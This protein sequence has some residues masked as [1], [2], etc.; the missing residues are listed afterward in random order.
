M[1][2]PERK[3]PAA[4]AGANGAVAVTPRKKSQAPDYRA[5][6][7]AATFTVRAIVNDDGHFLGLEVAY[8]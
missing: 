2:A 7:V 8:G 4:L 3:R 5:R 6:H 1:S